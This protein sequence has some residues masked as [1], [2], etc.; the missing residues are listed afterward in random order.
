MI[1]TG[2]AWVVGLF[3]MGVIIPAVLIALWPLAR[4]SIYAPRAGSFTPCK[5]RKVKEQ[6]RL[7]ALA[8]AGAVALCLGVAGFADLSGRG[9]PR[10]DWFPVL[11]PG[12]PG[13]LLAVG[14]GGVG[15]AFGVIRFLAHAVV[16]LAGGALAA[17]GLFDPGW[18]FVLGGAV[19]VLWGGIVL[20]RFLVSTPRAERTGTTLVV[21]QSVRADRDGLTSGVCVPVASE[22]ALPGPCTAPGRMALGALMEAASG[23]AGP[24][25]SLR[26]GVRRGTHRRRPG[27]RGP[28]LA[29]RR[30]SVSTAPRRASGRSGT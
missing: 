14:L 17:L 26:V 10:S 7:L 16:L 30:R 20:F 3:W 4:R 27:G 21:G 9:V 24:G 18:T 12:L 25:R 6:R 8:L 23:P 29:R 2:F 22:V 19:V 28:R 1:L 15:V 13:F 11:V 5:Q